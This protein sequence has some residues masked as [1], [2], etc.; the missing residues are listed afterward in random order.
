MR[1]NTGTMSSSLK[2]RVRTALKTAA[3][4][5]ESYSYSGRIIYEVR[6]R[7]DYYRTHIS[8]QDYEV[9]EHV[10]KVRYS[11]TPERV[12]ALTDWKNGELAK[13]IFSELGT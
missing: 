12:K 4:N 3:L 11:G 5:P 6:D 9:I 13:Q 7:M 2:E 8:L 1:L 10:I